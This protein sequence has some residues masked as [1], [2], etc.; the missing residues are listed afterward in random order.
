MPNDDVLSPLFRASLTAEAR[1]RFDH[2]AR[3]ESVLGE[4]LAAARSAWPELKVDTETFFLHVAQRLPP[5][6]TSL[7]A[8]KDL[9]TID[10]YLAC[11]CLHD[12]P[13]AMALF[14]ARYLSDL[15]A[16]LP[17]RR[18]SPAFD[19]DVK[20][21]VREKLFVR[22]EGRAPKIGEY[23]GRGDL[24]S[25]VRVL[26]MRTALNL[27]RSTKR[28]V[29]LADDSILADRAKADD[30]EIAHLKKRYR[31]DFAEAFHAALAKLRTRDRNVLRQHYVD[32]L[33]MEQIGL[34]YRVH[35][36]T[37]VRWIDKART[38]LAAETRRLLSARLR[39]GRGELDSIMRLIRSQLDVSLRTY[40]R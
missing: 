30:A 38:E 10:L 32:G 3:M 15:A 8:L 28:E 35:R 21:A 1:A 4:L 6:A 27:L 25:W 14:E 26:T 9:R 37:V 12:D 33:T 40:L 39:V 11:A 31:T 17:Q 13:A 36:I 20:Q 29:A 5:T 23:S 24:G 18:R 7:L 16:M 19:S 22:H 2:D 34:V